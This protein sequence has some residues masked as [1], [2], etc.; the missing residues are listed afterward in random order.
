[1]HRALE[2]DLRTWW[3]DLEPDETAPGRARAWASNLGLPDSILDD[4]RLVISDL[5]TNSVVHAQPA[6]GAPIPLSIRIG[7]NPRIVRIEVWDS[8]GGVA[9][10]IRSSADSSSQGGRRLRVVQELAERWGVALD[11]SP[12]VWAEVPFD[13]PAS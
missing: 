11:G 2:T 10:R 6:R 7:V 3:I 12:G 9:D 4:V 13:P 8:G 5:V 1:M